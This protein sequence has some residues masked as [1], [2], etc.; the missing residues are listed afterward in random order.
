MTI[1]RDIIAGL[2]NA[3]AHATGERPARETRVEVP[4]LDVRSIR[5]RLGL[6]QAEFA[7]KYGFSVGAVRNWEQ[8]IRRPERAARLLLAVIERDP[9]LVHETL[10]EL[11]APAA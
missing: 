9:D 10:E 2:E 5:E 1:G 7:V 11:T 8:G 3:L 4:V 6:T